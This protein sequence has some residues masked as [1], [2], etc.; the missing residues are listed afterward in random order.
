M[1]SL[2]FL[3]MLTNNDLVLNLGCFTEGNAYNLQQ[4]DG[5]EEIHR[6]NTRR[7][8]HKPLAIKEEIPLRGDERQ[9]ENGICLLIYL[10][11]EPKC[12][13]FKDLVTWISK[14][15]NTLCQHSL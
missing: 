11:H 7:E 1:K 12:A 15:N 4:L 5:K 6:D 10:L 3:R 2:S 13:D 9:P 14:R 8:L